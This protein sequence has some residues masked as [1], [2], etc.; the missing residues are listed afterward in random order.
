MATP[1]SAGPDSRNI[2]TGKQGDNRYLEA[3]SDTLDGAL[4]GAWRVRAAA[5]A[6]QCGFHET[7]LRAPVL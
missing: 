2:P 6:A 7:R 3:I 4:A 5:S 1:S